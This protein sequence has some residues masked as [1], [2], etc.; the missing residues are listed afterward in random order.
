MLLLTGFPLSC[1]N[2]PEI[3]LCRVCA[4]LICAVFVLKLLNKEILKASFY[5]VTCHVYLGL[6]C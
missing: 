2:T 1:K 5:Q 4:H 6:C 3:I